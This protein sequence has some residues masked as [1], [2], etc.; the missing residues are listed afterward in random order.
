[1]LLLGENNPGVRSALDEEL[2]M[3]PA[4]VSDIETVKRPFLRGRPEQV[5]F[6]FTLAH[7]RGPS[8]NDIDPAQSQRLNEITILRVFI[9]I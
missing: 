9:K 7:A 3:Q 1:M 5:F 2:R 6:V 4:I 8:A